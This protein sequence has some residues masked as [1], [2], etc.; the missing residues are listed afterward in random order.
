MEKNIPEDIIE[1]R[2]LLETSLRMNDH[3]KR[4][5]YFDSAIELSNDYLELNPHSHHKTYIENIK[6]TYLRS[7]IKNLPK[8][9]VDIKIWFNYTVLFMHKYPLEFNTIIEND[10][11]LKKIYNEFDAHYLEL[12]NLF[13]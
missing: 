8:S 7:L 10:P 5:N 3:D 1:T 12:K 11:I 9:N 2:K 13:L 4:V 6:M